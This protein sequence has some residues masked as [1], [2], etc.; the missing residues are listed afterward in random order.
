MEQ[1]ETP[2]PGHQELLVAVKG[3]GL[4]FADLIFLKGTYQGQ[5]AVPFVPGIEVFGEVVAHG[6]GAKGFSVGD[7][8]FGQVPSGGFAEF[9]VMD[10][11]TTVRVTVGMPADEAAGFYVNYGTAYSAL[12]QRGNARPGDIVLVLGASGGV[13]LAAVQIGKA[14]GLKVIADCRGRAK[15]DLVLRQGADIAVDYTSED[16]PAAVRE[17]T[18]GRGC[19]LVLDM[20]GGDATKAALKVIAWCGRLVVIGF[21]SGAL[22]K[23]PA[24]H[25]LVKNCS[26][27]GHWWG[28]YGKRDRIQLDSA[29]EKFV[30][31]LS[32]GVDKNGC[33]RHPHAEQVPE[34]LR[35]YADR[36]VLS[37]LVAIP[38]R[39]DS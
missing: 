27:I 38:S 15:Q 8:V 26:V 14:L 34:G 7:L 12:V 30:F 16:F 9:A 1:V 24:N 36:N 3:C 23:L 19:D 20:L 13:G 35:R 32:E 37:K 33:E 31:P 6:A 5:P 2:T 18:D 29:F 17:F 21:A 4:N 25:L 28:E 22:N 39:S 11:V 10:T